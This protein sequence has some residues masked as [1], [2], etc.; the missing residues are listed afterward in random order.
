MVVLGGGGYSYER[1]T[2]VTPQPENA[3]KALQPGSLSAHPATFEY[4]FDP[5]REFFI[6]NLLVR[7]HFIIEMMWWTGLASWEFEFPFPGSLIFTFLLPF[8]E[9]DIKAEQVP[10][11]NP[12]RL[13]PEILKP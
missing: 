4:M 9:E 13:T 5:D 3:R 2:P 8:L 1:G 12:H 7:L 6:D 10:H 11:P